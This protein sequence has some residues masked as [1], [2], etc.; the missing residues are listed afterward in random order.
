MRIAVTTTDGQKVDQHF[1]KATSFSI[2][3]M[4]DN[5]LKLV[6]TREVTS[7][8][9]CNSNVS[10]ESTHSFSSDRFSTVREKLSD[11]DKLYTV[12]IGETPRKQFEI[13]GIDV[14][15]CTCSIEKIPGCKGNCK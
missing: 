6:E 15:T 5:L 14:Q 9:D 2:Y 12:Q 11:C 4:D 3:D 1:G 7:Y 8:C 10:S 13:I